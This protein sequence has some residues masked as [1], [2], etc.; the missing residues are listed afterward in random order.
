[1]AQPN[2]AA[3][4]Q[5]SNVLGAEMPLMV[6]HPAVNQVAELRQ[7]I[8]QMGAQM[9]ACMTQVQNHFD[10][11]ITQVQNHL[12]T[13]MDQM[14]NHLDARM[15]QMQGHLDARITESE[16]RM[17]AEIGFAGRVSHVRALNSAASNDN[18]RLR[19]VPLPGAS[20]SV[21]ILAQFP[22]TRGHF[23][24]LSGPELSQWIL[25]YELVAEN[26]IPH[27]IGER[28]AMLADHWGIYL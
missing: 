19:F 26:D 14:Q 3:I 13:R 9:A 23:M 27:L 28:R 24:A 10:A 11:R 15:N 8:E 18:S 25:R 7:T 22:P 20:A 4:G 2:I 6:N 21:D 1:M 17:T 12:D 5:A 16:D